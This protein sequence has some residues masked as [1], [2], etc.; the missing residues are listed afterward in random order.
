LGVGEEL[1]VDD[2]GDPAFEAADR[3][4]WLLAGGA[5]ASVVGTA[6]G[7]EA[8]LGDRSDVDHVVHPTVP[9]A[10][11]PVTVLLTGGGV[12]RC[13]PGPGREPVP[14]GEPRDV[15][16]VGQ[17][18][19][20]DHGPDAGQFHQPRVTGQDYRLQLR[21][22]V[23]DLGLDRYEVGELL[24]GDPAAGLAGDVARAHASEHPLGL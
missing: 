13:G 12:Q 19:G 9:G 11:E 16:D 5:L 24:G 8:E 6:L 21:G 20:G 3:F 17:D 4:H 2:V 7:V 1:A 14:I 10:R 15:A 22:G 23:L 18:P